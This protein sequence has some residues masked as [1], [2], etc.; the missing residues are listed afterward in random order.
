MM[1]TPF[2]A[3]AL[4]SFLAVLCGAARAEEKI[5]FNR[6]IRP[7]LSNRCF[8]CHGPDEEERKADLRLDTREGALMDLGGYAA[9]VPGKAEESELFHR[10]TLDDDDEELMPPAGK[11]TRFNEAE[12]ALIKKWIAQEAH[13][14]NHWSYDQPV[15]PA[16]P[17][18]KRSDW[19][20][21]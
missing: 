2:Y 9:L 11:G 18:G 21:N 3:T 5:D 17:K 1:K 7:L 6:D 14:A 10:I 12:V 8:A 16:V 19:P 13:Y 15:R 20:V 4:G